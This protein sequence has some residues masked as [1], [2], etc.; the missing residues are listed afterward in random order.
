MRRKKILFRGTSPVSCPQSR[1]CNTI[2]F[3]V[4]RVHLTSEEPAGGSTVYHK[5]ASPRFCFKAVE[6]L[7]FVFVYLHVLGDREGGSGTL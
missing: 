2:P 1:V 7:G 6:Y 4:D 3:W 5:T